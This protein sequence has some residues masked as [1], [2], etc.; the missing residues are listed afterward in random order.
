MSKNIYGFMAVQSHTVLR[1]TAPLHA[2]AVFA[3]VGDLANNHGKA[4]C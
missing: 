2:A 1:R 4:K 3:V